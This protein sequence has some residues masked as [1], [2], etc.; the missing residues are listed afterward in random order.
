[1]YCW[2][3]RRAAPPVG[4][5]ACLPLASA[6]G[7]PAQSDSLLRAWQDNCVHDNRDGARYFIAEGV[8]VLVLLVGTGTHVHPPPIPLS[9]PRGRC[10][11][12]RPCILLHLAL[13]LPPVRLL[14]SCGPLQCRACWQVPLTFRW[15]WAAMHVLPDLPPLHLRHRCAAL[16]VWGLQATAG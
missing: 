2:P 9:V 1:M 10:S 14:H 16:L 5:Y 12:C 4:G 3:G 8:C 6:H 15:G 7:C 13:V 11:C